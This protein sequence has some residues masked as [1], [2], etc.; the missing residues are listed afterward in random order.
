MQISTR[1][2]KDELIPLVLKG[3]I[4]SLK[5]WSQETRN[6]LRLRETHDEWDSPKADPRLHMARSRAA[7]LLREIADAYAAGTL[8]YC[9]VEKHPDKETY[10][11][12][13]SRR[14]GSS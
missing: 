5:L 9:L 2:I 3:K 7:E 4:R 6:G 12:T 13:F 1:R 14:P 11:I 8:T 10:N